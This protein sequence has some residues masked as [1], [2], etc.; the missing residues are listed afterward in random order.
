MK[1]KLDA[2][3][4]QLRHVSSEPN[5]GGEEAFRADQTVDL[6]TSE[7]GTPSAEQSLDA[8]LKSKLQ[9]LDQVS[10]SIDETESKVCRS[11]CQKQDMCMIAVW[12]PPYNLG[13]GGCQRLHLTS[14]AKRLLCTKTQEAQNLHH[15]K[16]LKRL[17][18]S[19]YMTQHCYCGSP[20]CC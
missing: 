8:E 14:E 9:H 4:E 6:G 5:T 10:K 15:L 7:H 2:D 3:I 19:N 17:H 20:P 11:S 16:H 1:Q 18:C 12:A 13:F